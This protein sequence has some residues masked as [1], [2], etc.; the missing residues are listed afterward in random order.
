MKK[1]LRYGLVA[2][3]AV[4][5]TAPA[6]AVLPTYCGDT[7]VP[8]CVYCVDHGEYVHKCVDISPPPVSG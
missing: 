5:F 7:W 2:A 4:A 6:S 3:A 8:P 1:I